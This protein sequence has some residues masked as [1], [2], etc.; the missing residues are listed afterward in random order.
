MIL[1]MLAAADATTP[2]DF[3][4]WIAAGFIALEIVFNVYSIIKKQ[5]IKLNA[6]AAVFCAASLSILILIETKTVADSLALAIIFV[7]IVIIAA[8][9]AGIL[10]VHEAV[11]QV[12]K[13]KKLGS[14]NYR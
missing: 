14:A 9:L 4:I 1:N 2:N 12:K 13:I 10:C 6:I 11:Y 3:N 8:I 7:V 5:R